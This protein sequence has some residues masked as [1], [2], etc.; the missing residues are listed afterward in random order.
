MCN[1]CGQLEF[2]KYN[3]PLH[4]CEPCS[5][6][7]HSHPDR[8]SHKPV[9]QSGTADTFPLELL[10]VIC[11]ETSHY[12]CFTRITGSGKD[13]WVFFDSMASRTG[14]DIYIRNLISGDYYSLIFR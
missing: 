1:D 5:A 4:F 12:V 8:Q 10:S 3:T 7:W 11:I 13:Q 6:L 9:T 2:L 14:K